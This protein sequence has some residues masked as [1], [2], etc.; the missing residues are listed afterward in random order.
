MKKPLI[1]IAVILLVWLILIGIRPDRPAVEGSAET[2]DG[3]VFRVSVIKPLS[4]RPLGGLFGLIP[5]RD[6]GFDIENPG[7]EVGQVRHDRLELTAGD[8]NLFIATDDAG[9][10][11]SDTHLVVPLDLGGRDRILNCRPA[12]PAVG[13][14]VSAPRVDDEGFDG[15]FRIELST[16]AIAETGKL[17][18]WPPAPLTVVGSFHQLSPGEPTPW[19]GDVQT[20]GALRGMFHEDQT[21]EMVALSSLLPDTELYAVGA[22]A[23]LAGEVTVIGGEAYLSYPDE[24]GG[25]RTEQTRQSD[26]GATLLVVTAV[27]SWRDVVTEHAIPFDEL[28]DAIAKLATVSGM[29]LDG[30]IPFLLEGTFDDLQWHV[31]DGSR[32]ISGGSSHKDHQAASV[33]ERRDRASA[34]L[35]GFYSSSDQGVFTHMGSKTHIHCVLD[36]PLSSGHVDGV[37][38]PA[39]TTVRFPAIALR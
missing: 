38:I 17:I 28:D 34:T 1:I 29:D 15:E 23:D 12:D 9:K 10:V 8:W 14:L 32:L 39:G 25:T 16:C 5:A 21:G 31:I 36:E 13:H 18:N 26:V 22:L 7:A 2:P 3:P 30:R 33:I 24:A 20:Y 11:T 4:G 35:V 37:V 19:N 27:P 6:L